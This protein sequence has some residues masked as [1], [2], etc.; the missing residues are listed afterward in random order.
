MNRPRYT[1]VIVA[2][3]TFP[4]GMLGYWV[5]KLA[6]GGPRRRADGHITAPAGAS[7]RA[8]RS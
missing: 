8:A 3:R 4:T 5:R 7:G 6:D 1:R 2:R